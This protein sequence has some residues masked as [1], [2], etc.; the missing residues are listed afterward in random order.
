MAASIIAWATVVITVGGI[1]L[2]GVMIARRNKKHPK[3]IEFTAEGFVLHGPLGDRTVRWSEIVSAGVSCHTRFIR[4]GGF[5]R[6]RFDW[7]GLDIE[8]PGRR[9]SPPRRSKTKN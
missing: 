2:L 7:W 8:T 3:K 4:G 6:K 5:R 1:I 9:R